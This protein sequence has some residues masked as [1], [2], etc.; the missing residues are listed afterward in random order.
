MP[1]GQLR[2]FVDASSL[3][4]SGRSFDS[5]VYRVLRQLVHAKKVQIIVTDH[6]VDEVVKHWSAD[7]VESLRFLHNKN[8]ILWARELLGINLPHTERTKIRELS[9][10]RMELTFRGF[11]NECSARVISVDSVKPSDV[12]KM[13]S[14]NAGLFSGAAK[15]DQFPDAFIISSI[16]IEHTKKR[17]DVIVSGDKDFTNA[18]YTPEIE[19]VHS[20]IALMARLG[21]AHSPIDLLDLLNNQDDEIWNRFRSELEQLQYIDASD[22][23]TEVNGVEIVDVQLKTAAI[24]TFGDQHIATGKA[25]CSCIIDANVPD[26]RDSTW[27]PKTETFTILALGSINIVHEFEFDYSLDVKISNHNVTLQ[28]GTVI[29]NRIVE[30]RSSP[31]SE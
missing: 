6:T 20:L 19:L 31:S 21:V 18:N 27:D 7:I 29:G 2:I 14:R 26:Y 8:S 3:I 30:F 9:W 12:L 28:G 23:D 10:S 11:L 1:Q 4:S 16:S 24:Y 13:Y 17:I 15:K 5:G 25:I 22:S